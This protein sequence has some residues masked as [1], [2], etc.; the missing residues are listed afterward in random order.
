[1]IF[2]EYLLRQGQ[3][4]LAFSAFP[5]P[6]ACGQEEEEEETAASQGLLTFQDVVIE[7]SQDEWEFLDS[8]QWELY[9]DVMLENYKNL[10]SLGLVSKPGHL[11]TF[12]EQKK[13]PWDVKGTE[14]IAIHP[15][16]GAPPPRWRMVTS[17]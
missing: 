2:P 11:V 14:T 3:E 12:M 8:T 13:G 16:T 15:G 4:K 1:M 9:R 6:S 7:F 10:V 17:G 5:D